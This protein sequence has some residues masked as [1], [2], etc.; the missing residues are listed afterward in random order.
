MR[1]RTLAILAA[2]VPF[3]FGII[4]LIRTGADSRGVVMAVAA[5]IGAAAVL[6]VSAL[7]DR[8]PFVRFALAFVLAALLAAVAGLSVGGSLPAVM[9]VAL[10]MAL[11]DGLFVALAARSD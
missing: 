4:R 8:M 3:A 2:A 11:F 1:N 5:F 10:G 9:T 7:R 6:A